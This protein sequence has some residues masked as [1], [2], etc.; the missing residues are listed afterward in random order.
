M[1]HE[2]NLQDEPFKLVDEGTKTI[3]MRVYDEKRRNIHI[4][5]II[6]FNNDN[7]DKIVK[8]EVINMHI[9]RVLKN[10]MIHLIK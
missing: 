2:M 8:T 5:D 9:F 3:E 10:Y 1:I 6:E 7:T 4:K